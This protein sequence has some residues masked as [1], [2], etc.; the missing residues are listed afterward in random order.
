MQKTEHSVVQ[1]TIIES[2]CIIIEILT[3]R[4]MQWKLTQRGLGCVTID[5]HLGNVCCKNIFIGQANH[6]N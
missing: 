6:E 3:A 1:V 5:C 4:G 2:L